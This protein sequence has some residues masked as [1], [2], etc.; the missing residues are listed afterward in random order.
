MNPIDVNRSHPFQI[1]L[2]KLRSAWKRG[3]KIG[4]RSTVPGLLRGRIMLLNGLAFI[5]L[6]SVVSFSVAYA[7]IGYT[8][9]YGPLYIVPVLIVVLV[10]NRNGKFRAS[11]NLYLV[12]SLLVISYWCY[13]GRGTG[14]EYTLIGLATT[15]TLISEDRVSVI[16]ANVMCAII[17]IAYLVYHTQTPFVPDPAINYTIVP[18][19]ILLNTVAVI[20]FQ[21]AFFRDLA[22]HYDEKLTVKYNELR[23][24][25]A[26][27]KSNNEEIKAINEKLQDLTNQLESLVRQKS[28]ELQ[29][30]IDA[31]D[32]NMYSCIND[33]EGKFVQVNEQIVKASGYTA[34]ELLGKHYS[35]LATPEHQAANEEERRAALLEGRVWRGEVEHRSK[36]GHL[37]WFDCVVIP[38]RNDHGQIEHFLSLGLPIT[39]RKLHEQIQEKTRGIL[40]SIAFSASHNIRGPMARIKGLANL[41]EMDVFDR[42]EFKMVARKFSVCS[43]ELNT[44]TS[45][46]VDFVHNHQELLLR[47]KSRKP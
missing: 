37:Y 25:E 13:E 7:A 28:R 30:Y 27:L 44:A 42:D 20:S 40:E 21:I 22:K 16:F 23:K 5:V 47:V 43:D 6:I 17:F 32:I 46:L 11:Q 26:E 33:K 29:T 36:S 3:L 45:E 10:L 4:Y 41:I 34:E 2:K 19:A 9:F 12:G 14:N 1:V 8:Y 38:I 18:A 31:I 35:M 39:E 24:A 15:A